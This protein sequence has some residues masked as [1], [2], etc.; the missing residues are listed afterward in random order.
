MTAFGSPRAPEGGRHG[1]PSRMAEAV[2]SASA[3]AHGPREG[4][5]PESRPLGPLSR[6]GVHG[7]G[8]LT[9]RRV[10]PCD[11]GGG[12]QIAPLRQRRALTGVGA[13]TSSG[14]P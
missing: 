7:P 5:R 3:Y 12:C 1:S 14:A 13:R 9:A 2:L 6:P 4:S 10:S 8:P 11:Q